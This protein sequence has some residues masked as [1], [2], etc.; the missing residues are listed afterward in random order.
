MK[1]KR[2]TAS[3]RLLLAQI[4]DLSNKLDA[5]CMYLQGGPNDDFCESMRDEIDYCNALVG[6]Y[7]RGQE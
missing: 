5:A 2:L 1:L 7:L 3:E 4:L 6:D